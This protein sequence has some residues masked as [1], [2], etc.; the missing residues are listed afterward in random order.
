[1]VFILP[2]AVFFL[3]ARVWRLRVDEMMMKQSDQL[4]ASYWITHECI[5]VSVHAKLN[6][7][8]EG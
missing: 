1:M 5:I 6:L 3:I 7:V 4:L 8:L 2:N